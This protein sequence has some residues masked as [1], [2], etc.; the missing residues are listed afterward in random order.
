MIEIQDRRQRFAKAPSGTR[1]E[2]DIRAR[3]ALEEQELAG[4]AI[5]DDARK[6]TDRRE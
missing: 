5:F 6:R 2:I 1:R 4:L 3:V